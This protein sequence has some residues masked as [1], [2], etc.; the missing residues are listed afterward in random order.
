M[1]AERLP[2]LC[3]VRV[4]SRR[5]TQ[6]VIILAMFQWDEPQV[7]RWTTNREFDHG[8]LDFLDAIIH[9]SFISGHTA[10]SFTLIQSLE[11]SSMPLLLPENFDSNIFECVA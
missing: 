3:E 4:N 6:R 2:A 8:A 7:P 11:A 10:C 1:K 5:G 9:D